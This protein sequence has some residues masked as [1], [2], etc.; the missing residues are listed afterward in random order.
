MPG[1]AGQA[2]HAVAE[3]RGQDLTGIAAEGLHSTAD[4]FQVAR[5]NRMPTV[6]GRDC[7]ADPAEN[8]ERPLFGQQQLVL[9]A[10]RYRQLECADHLSP[11]EFADGRFDRARP[12]SA[13]AGRRLSDLARSARHL[14]DDDFVGQSAAQ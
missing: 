11:L 3:R 1:I 7:F 12:A 14:A 6:G 5:E 13:A 2:R 10:H 9:L 8:G 4:C